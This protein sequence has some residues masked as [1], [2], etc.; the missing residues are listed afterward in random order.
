MQYHTLISLPP[1]PSHSLSLHPCQFCSAGQYYWFIWVT[2]R[3]P[4]W[5]TSGEPLDFYIPNTPLLTSNNTV[6]APKAAVVYRP[7]VCRRIDFIIVKRP[8][9]G[10]CRLERMMQCMWFRWRTSWGF[11]KYPAGM[12]NRCGVE[13]HFAVMLLLVC[14]LQWYNCRQL[15]LN[16]IPMTTLNYTPASIFRNWL[17]NIHQ[18]WTDICI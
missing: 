13:T 3:S 18:M 5:K 16:P 4:K 9:L 14:V 6:K 17:M 12:Q 2:Y 10:D 8:Q 7:C 11:C 15:P 1:S